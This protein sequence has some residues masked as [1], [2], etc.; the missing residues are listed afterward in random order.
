[1]SAIFECVPNVSEGRDLRIIDECAEAI[2]TSGAQLAHRTS[3]DVHNRSV[4][5]FFGTRDVVLAAALALAHVA[6]ER[7]DLRTHEG[8]HPRIG[9]L[10]VLPFIP[11]RHATM[12]DAAEI[13]H[14]AAKRLWN[15]LQ[16]PSF[17]YGAASTVS[18]PRSL[19]S[20][21]GGEF[22][23]LFARADT[24]ERPDV[25]DIIAHQSAGATAVGAREMLI[26]FNIEL[27]TSDL[28]LAQRIARR[29][30]ERNGGLRTLRA[31][32]VQL[33]PNRVQVSCNITAVDAVSLRTLVALV[34]LHAERFGVNVSGCELIGLIPRS[35]LT[36]VLKERL[37]NTVS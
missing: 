13:A 5:T 37:A 24:G 4:F 3:D 31:I 8:A 11:I 26:A 17:Y 28:T 34:R 7:I 16:I 20:V 21:R 30:R 22:E 6:R 12:S 9:A 36:A 10:D 18:P 1:M 35:A 2:R 32:G 15:E 29:I 33:G 27:A 23:G 19:P 25:G 14:E